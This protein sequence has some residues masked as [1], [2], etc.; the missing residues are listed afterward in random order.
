[1]LVSKV[2][3]KNCQQMQLI[4]ISLEETLLDVAFRRSHPYR[5]PFRVRV[6]FL[7]GKAVFKSIFKVKDREEVPVSHERPSL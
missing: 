5:V 4:L 1:M 6:T 2:K 7:V 3:K